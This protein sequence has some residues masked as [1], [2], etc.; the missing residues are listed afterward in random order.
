MCDVS[1]VILT[2]A[3]RS[4]GL[5]R[6]RGNIE[7]DFRSEIGADTRCGLVDRWCCNGEVVQP[8]RTRRF[9]NGEPEFRPEIGERRARNIPGEG[10]DMRVGL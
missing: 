8:V 4:D 1:G 7:P 6:D 9:G 10:L 5:F 3:S 2:A